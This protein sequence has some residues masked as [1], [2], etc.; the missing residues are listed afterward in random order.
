MSNHLRQVHALY[1]NERKKWLGRARFSILNKHCA[2]V[3]PGRSMHCIV[4]TNLLYSQVV[5]QC[6]IQMNLLYNQTLA[7]TQ[8]LEN[9]ITRSYTAT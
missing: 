5:T 7:A 4:Q 8:R 3:Q 1:G 6:L 9:V 2:G